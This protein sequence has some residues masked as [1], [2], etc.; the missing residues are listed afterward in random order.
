[1]KNK[2]QE[3]CYFCLKWLKSLGEG[4]GYNLDSGKQLLT[5]KVHFVSIDPVP[6]G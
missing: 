3:Q 4:G 1:M 5:I 2:G 6:R